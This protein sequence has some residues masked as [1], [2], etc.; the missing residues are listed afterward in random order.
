MIGTKVE[1]GT[2][3]GWRKLQQPGIARCSCGGFISSKRAAEGA[4]VCLR[5]E[6]DADV[7]A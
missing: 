5:C 3:A 6:R 4:T 7:Q 2:N 1:G